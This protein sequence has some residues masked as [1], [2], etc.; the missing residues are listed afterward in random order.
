VAIGFLAEAL[1]GAVERLA[2]ELGA[3]GDLLEKTI[4]VGLPI[5]LW[6]AT[7]LL[8]YRFVPSVRLRFTDALAGAL[9]TGVLL[10]LISIASGVLYGKTR[11]W[12]VVYGSLTSLLVFLYSVYLYAS[13]L[14]LG[15]TVAVEWSRPRTVGP[16]EP[17]RA[18][19]RRALRGLFVRER[20]K[21]R[22]GDEA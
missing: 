13:A 9:V 14:L 18:R 19:A 17:L 15:A 1:G 22:Y 10:L 6:V 11:E 12:S 2:A 4:A 20:R 16:R 8:L 3:K 5:V 21:G 7:A